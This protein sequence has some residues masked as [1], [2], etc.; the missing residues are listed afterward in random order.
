MRMEGTRKAASAGMIRFM[1]LPVAVEN[2][3]MSVQTPAPNPTHAGRAAA[4]LPPDIIDTMDNIPAAGVTETLSP[5]LAPLQRGLPVVVD[6]R[7]LPEHDRRY[8][9]E[10]VV[11][12]KIQR[13]AS[14]AEDDIDHERNE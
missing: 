1:L 10:E 3:G 5:R 9:P 8:D 13:I 2:P 12:G 7:A 6:V 4:R 14:H 11:D